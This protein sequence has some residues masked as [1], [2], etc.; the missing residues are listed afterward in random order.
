MYTP[1]MVHNE[2]N[3][4]ELFSVTSEVRGILFSDA[5]K[6]ASLSLGVSKNSSMHGE[7]TVHYEYTSS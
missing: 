5:P 2:E 1:K 7:V 3:D 6:Y 4:D